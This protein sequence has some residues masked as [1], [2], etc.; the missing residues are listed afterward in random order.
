MVGR[1]AFHEGHGAGE[2]GDVALEY[3]FHEFARARQRLALAAFEIGVDY[4]RLA[5]A[6]VDGEAAELIV[7]FN[8]FHD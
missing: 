2:G 7:V 5:H 4:R 6:L 1:K 8:M 3:S